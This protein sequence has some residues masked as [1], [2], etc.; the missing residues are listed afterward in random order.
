MWVMRRLTEAGVQAY[1]P[2]Y[3]NQVEVNMIIATPQMTVEQ[4]ASLAKA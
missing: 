1:C 4:I 3:I 2:K